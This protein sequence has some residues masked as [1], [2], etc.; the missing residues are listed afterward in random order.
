V[1]RGPFTLAANFAADDP[2]EVPVGEAL[3]VV[4]ATHDGARLNDG[5][6]ELPPRAG[7]LVR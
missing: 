2:A 4:V 5:H 3:E 1:R 7:A 6:V